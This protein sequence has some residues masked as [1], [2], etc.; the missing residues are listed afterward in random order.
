MST[1]TLAIR[2]TTHYAFSEPVM[3]ALQR[4]RLTPKETQGQRIIEWKMHFEHAQAELAYDDQHFNHVTLIVLGAVEIYA[5][6]TLFYN[7]FCTLLFVLEPLLIFV[8]ATSLLYL[9]YYQ[10]VRRLKSE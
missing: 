5:P 9:F 1:L 8:T 6:T 10:A 2:H 7:V 3:H 4:L